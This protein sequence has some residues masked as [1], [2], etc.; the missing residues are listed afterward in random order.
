MIVVDHN[1]MKDLEWWTACCNQ[2]NRRSMLQKDENRRSIDTE[3]AHHINYLELLVGF[4]ALK[5]FAVNCCAISIL[6]L[7]DNIT[8]I[9][10]LNR[11]NPFCCSVRTGTGDLEVVSREKVSDTCRT[12]PRKREHP[13]RLGSL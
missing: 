10:Y 4:L 2:H 7:L 5:S 1:M 8:A 9:V 11:G 6:L 3:K 12:P 13:S